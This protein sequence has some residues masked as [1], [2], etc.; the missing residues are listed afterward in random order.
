MPGA[1]PHL[2]LALCPISV[3]LAGLDLHGPPGRC[4]RVLTPSQKF[5]PPALGLGPQGWLA[6]GLSEPTLNWEG[7][8][9]QNQ[10]WSRLSCAL[11][12][13]QG[14]EWLLSTP[15]D[16]HPFPP[17]HAG[18]RGFSIDCHF[19]S[20]MSGRSTLRMVLGMQTQVRCDSGLVQ[21][22]FTSVNHSFLKKK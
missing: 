10:P 3:C 4:S 20:D 11:W 7:V 16:A 8:L 6:D 17:W 5:L 15:Q 21:T 22:W 14:P 12:R 9:N 13:P 18:H 2:P 19:S 1:H